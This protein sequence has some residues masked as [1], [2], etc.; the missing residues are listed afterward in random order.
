LIDEGTVVELNLFFDG[1]APKPKRGKKGRKSSAAVAAEPEEEAPAED[2]E[3]DNMDGAQDADAGS[4]VQGEISRAKQIVKSGTSYIK[5]IT[6]EQTMTFEEIVKTRALCDQAIQGIV[7]RVADKWF[8]RFLQA[9]ESRDLMS[10]RD[11]LDHLVKGRNKW[12]TQR[13]L[14]KT[15]MGCE[16]RK[17]E[18]TEI[19]LKKLRKVLDCVVGAA[20]CEKYQQTFS[21]PQMF[22]DDINRAISAA[23]AAEQAAASAASAAAP[24]A[25]PQQR[26]LL[27]MFG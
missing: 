2:D 20:Y 24:A 15:I 21:V 19:V 11:Q 27:G 23:A 4:S 25:Q 22:R 26:G 12:N 17:I 3:D 13:W 10:L 16:V 5:D 18:E 14:T 8:D 1:G 6:K 7:D 9:A